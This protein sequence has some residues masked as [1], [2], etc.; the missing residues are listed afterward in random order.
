MPVS[1]PVLILSQNDWQKINQ[2]YGNPNNLQFSIDY[3]LVMPKKFRPAVLLMFALVLFILL[4]GNFWA[5][6]EFIR[7]ISRRTL[8]SE[9]ESTSL[10]PSPVSNNH[11]DHHQQQQPSTS[12]NQNETANPTESTPQENKSP[13]N[14]EPAILAMPYCLIALLLCFAVGWLLLIYYFPK[15]MIYVLQGKQINQIVLDS[16]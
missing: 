11:H 15:V 8:D 1:I 13:S 14:S 5:A 6:D 4:C 16:K 12:H 7:K 3:G 2:T 9:S 10:N